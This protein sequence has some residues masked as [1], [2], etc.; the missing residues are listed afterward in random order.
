MRTVKKQ[1]NKHF[2]NLLTPPDYDY[3]FSY[4]AQATMDINTYTPNTNLKF[5]AISGESRFVNQTLCNESAHINLIMTDAFLQKEL[6][7]MALSLAALG[8]SAFY[9]E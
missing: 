1:F 4:T 9:Y 6:S 2:T 5:S 7:D 8:F 3:D